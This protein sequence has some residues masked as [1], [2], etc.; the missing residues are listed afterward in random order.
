LPPDRLVP[1][2]ALPGFHFVSLQKGCPVPPE[3]LPL[4]NLMDEMADFADT[5]ALIANL[6]LVVAVD[7]AVVHL[8]GALGK[9]VWVLLAIPTD[10][11]WMLDRQDSPW[12]PTARLFRQPKRGDWETPLAQVVDALAD[13]LG[14][15]L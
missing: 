13:L 7:T 14:R 10:W 1:L 8:A 3:N 9:P 2:R 15:G 12:Y 4:T 11:R 6:D 5:A